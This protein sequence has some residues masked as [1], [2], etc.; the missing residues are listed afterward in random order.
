M[1]PTLSRRWRAGALAGALATAFSGCAF[2]L[3]PSDTSVQMFEWNWND[4]ATECT[5]FLGP[6]GFGAIQISPPQAS[7]V[8]STWWGVY[9]PVNYVNLTSKFGTPAQLQSMIGA[10]HAAGVRVY[11][12]VVV[13][14]MAADS[15]TAT[16]GSTWN[17]GALA[18]PY[19]SASDFH[20]ACDIQPAD[21]NA[22]AGRS[23]V[24]T[25]RLSGMP[26]LDSESA[27]VR[28]QVVNYLDAL[29]TLGIDGFRF[30]A[31]KHQAAASLQAI[32]G[33]VKATHA[34]TNQGEAIWVTQEIVPDG[35]VVR[36]DYFPIGTVNEF[37]FAYAMR[38]AWRDAN[39]ASPSTIP[40]MR[41]TWNN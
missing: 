1:Q 6:Q 14:Q 38:D 25:C 24:Q 22:A 10:C 20:A 9:Q 35:E 30:D 3:N 37:Q 31:A 4:L 19:F 21:Y 5:Q 13:N 11:A 12:D 27:Y 2:A 41:G 40:A 33:A 17:A 18:Y 39:G 16:D 7:K 8:T 26:D 28:A 34:T 36:S 29:L 32:M 23:N 15:G